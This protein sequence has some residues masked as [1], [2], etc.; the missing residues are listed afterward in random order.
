[1]SITS[2]QRMLTALNGG[3]PQGLFYPLKLFEAEP[4]LVRAF[5]D[6]AKKCVSET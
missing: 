4:N 5:A 3:V 2:K 6:E 1:M